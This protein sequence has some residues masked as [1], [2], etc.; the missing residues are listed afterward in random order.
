MRG[1]PLKYATRKRL[2]VLYLQV[3]TSQQLSH[4]TN[5][6]LARYDGADSNSENVGKDKADAVGYI[7]TYK[8]F[9]AV[10]GRPAHNNVRRPSSVLAD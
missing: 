9:T 4:A 5:A 7:A 10:V 1:L 3:E 8:T 2:V 6:L